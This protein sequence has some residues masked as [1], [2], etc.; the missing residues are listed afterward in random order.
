[1]ACRIC[2]QTKYENVRRNAKVNPNLPFPLLGDRISH[3]FR[4]FVE[5][6]ST[7]TEEDSSSLK[8][9]SWKERKGTMLTR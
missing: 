8:H 6:P 1:M 7:K 3:T 5:T 2:V 4:R 9:G